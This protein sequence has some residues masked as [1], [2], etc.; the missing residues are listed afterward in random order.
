MT[1]YQEQIIK[2]SKEVYSKDYLCKQIIQAKKFIDEHFY[3]NINLSG[4]A[5][6]AHVSRFHFIRLFKK[7]YGRAPYQYLTEVRIKKAKEFLRSGKTIADVCA[8]VGFESI[9]SFTGLFKKITGSTPFAF[10]NKK[11]N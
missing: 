3:N 2:L 10:Q 9:T 4:I 6:K 8:S 11:R 5:Q 1:Y 7:N